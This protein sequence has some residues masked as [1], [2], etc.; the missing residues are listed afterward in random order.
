MTDYKI[1]EIDYKFSDKMIKKWEQEDRECL[2][3]I[4][5]C[6]NMFLAFCFGAFI[7]RIMM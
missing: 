2:A 5:K 3:F 1:T 7:V 6:T 4:N